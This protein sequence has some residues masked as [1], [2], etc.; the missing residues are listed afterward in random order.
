LAATS[1]SRKWRYPQ[2][3]RRRPSP[4][5]KGTLEICAASKSATSSSLRTKYA[6]ALNCAFLDENGK[7][8]IMEMGCYGIGVS[9]IVGAAI[10][11][12]NDDK[13]IILPP[14]IA[15]SQV[16]IVPMGYHKSEAVK[17]ASDQLPI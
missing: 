3:R 2:R 5:G 10:E 11:Q 15:R 9:R 7:S 6:E 1:R 16:C 13:G 17:A 4:D 12:G 8:Q 14:A